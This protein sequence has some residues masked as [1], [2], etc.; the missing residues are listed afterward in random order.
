MS[1]ERIHR[2]LAAILAADVVGYGR[3]MEVD[4]AGTLTALKSR[5]RE[6]LD[7]LLAKHHG[8]LFKV[9]GDGVLVE[10]A[11]A[12]NAAQCSVE[13]QRGMAAANGDLPRDRHIMLRIGI[14][15]CEVIVEGGDRYGEGVNI[16]ARLEGIA[17]PNGICISAKVY[18]E[19][20]G[21]LALAYEDLG[22]RQLKNMATPVRVY[23][24][25]VNDIRAPV[26]ADPPLQ[27]K[28]SVAVLPFVN[29]SGDPEQEFLS[30]GITEDLITLLSRFRELFVISRS[31]SFTFKG[32]ALNIPE[33]ARRLGVQYVVEGSIRKIGDRVRVTAQLIDGRR[34]DHI[35]AE[36]YDRELKD[37]FEL[38]DEVVRT[39]AATMVGRLGHATHERTKRR[40]ASDLRAYELYQRGLEH[41]FAWTP[42]DNRKARDNFQAAIAIEPDYA[43]AQAALSEAMFRSWLNGWSEDARRDFNGFLESA[44]RSVQLDNEDSR[45]HAALGL[46]YMYH[47]RHDLARMHLEKAI[48]LNPSNV[49]AVAYLSRLELFAGNPALAIART[50]EASRLNPFGKYGWYLGQSYY[51]ARRYSDAIA[52]LKGLS[53]PTAMVLAWLAASYAMA[54]AL[55]E[56]D[57]SRESFRRTA[58][59]DPALGA[60]S[61]AREWRLFF[62]R[63]WPFQNPEDLDHL[64]AGL[65][66]AGLLE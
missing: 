18:E 46:A 44:E 51:A 48:G 42:A 65:R 59:S 6:L 3:L 52:S 63:R 43:A 23:R 21:R 16:A 57:L 35:W 5:R 20:K 36:R 49:H 1:E 4:E 33:I 62:S 12:V 24:I 60:I 17:E 15:L 56:T 39:M 47:E 13:L 7:P 2:R 37:I 19:I 45:T 27:A 50:E 10:F 41:F 14:N 34:D 31:S 40:P 30:D 11:S 9:A 32:Q 29:M 8:R 61:D 55:R 53:S 22:E 66:K 64:F 25:V 54:G 38:Q 26:P 58:K 28:P